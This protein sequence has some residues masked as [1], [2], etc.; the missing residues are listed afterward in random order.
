MS[1]FNIKSKH[2]TTKHVWF[3]PFDPKKIGWGVI[4]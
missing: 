3:E 2:F 1:Q 4:D